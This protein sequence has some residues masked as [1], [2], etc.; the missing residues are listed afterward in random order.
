MKQ[1][2]III[3]AILSF[4]LSRFV[5]CNVYKYNDAIN[6]T[7]AED[8]VYLQ[9]IGYIFF[10]LSFQCMVLLFNFT[11]WLQYIEYFQCKPHLE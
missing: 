4:I 8:A 11:F 3:N 2:E 10:N 6:S 9:S 5:Y 1:T 7:M